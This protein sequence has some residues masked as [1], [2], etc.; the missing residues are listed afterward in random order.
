[1]PR[2]KKQPRY[3]VISVRT[4]PER[5]ALLKRYQHALA[6]QLGR[7]ISIAEAAFLVI[8]GRAMEMDRT[9]SRHEMLQTPTASLDRIRK[10]WASQHTLAAAEWDVLAEYVQIAADV[11]RPEPCRI[12]PTIPSRDSYRALL[13]VFEVVYQRRN[14]HPS[15][16]AWQYVNNLDGDATVGRL[17]DDDA[18]QQ[19][20]A[21][22]NQIAHHKDRLRLAE[23]YQRP[24]NIGWCVRTAIREEGVDSVTLDHLLAPYWSTLWGLA[25]RG[26]WIRHHQPVRA[27]KT[28]EAEALRRMSLPPAI[29][30]GDLTVSFA[31]S[32]GTDFTTEIEFRA[33]RRWGWRIRRYPEWMEC[34][35]TLEDVN[36]QP[37]NGRY[38]S[39]VVATAQESTT[40]TLWLEQRTLRVKLP[41]AQW[42]AL[43]DLFQQAWK[44]PH[45]AAV[46]APVATGLRRAG[47]STTALL[48]T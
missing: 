28:T 8:E 24:G 40:R 44:S 21:V 10:R 34:R 35:A 19:H 37:W 32:E 42:H 1:M 12:Q 17:S 5:L 45:L 25:A 3:Q 23:P 4:N 41:E 9:A 27:M 2:V 20:Q 13:N 38:F 33:P 11:E 36:D 31:P 48:R 26:H 39:T 47:I 30:R 18:D 6:D 15:N 22:L 46:A 7:S 16:H 43:R 29:T 14:D